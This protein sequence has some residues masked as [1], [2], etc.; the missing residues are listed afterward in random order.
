MCIVEMP[1]EKYHT[2]QISIMEEIG[3]LLLILDER[4]RAVA[5][6]LFLENL[7]ISGFLIS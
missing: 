1:D 4:S 7:K 2:R 3:R 6:N 5:T